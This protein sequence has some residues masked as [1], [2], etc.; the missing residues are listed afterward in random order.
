MYAPSSQAFKLNTPLLATLSAAKASRALGVS[1]AGN[2]SRAL[3]ESSSSSRRCSMLPAAVSDP[4]GGATP[5]ASDHAG[6][7]SPIAVAP[8]G[9]GD[10][11]ECAPPCA[12]PLA[13]LPPL[14]PPALPELK[15][16][17]AGQ[18]PVLSHLALLVPPHA[19][20]L[21]ARVSRASRRR[22]RAVHTRDT[23]GKVPPAVLQYVRVCTGTSRWVV[24]QYARVCTGTSWWVVLQYARV[25]GAEQ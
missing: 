7:A 22:Y 20:Q 25:Y 19:T 11:R 2:I 10:A 8:R 6:G 1:S 13:L 18:E 3:V 4:A 24:L 23:H 17:R 21:G 5:I 12:L 14:P 9:D 15:D 16:E